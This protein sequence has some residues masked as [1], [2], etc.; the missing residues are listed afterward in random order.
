MRLMIL[1][2]MLEFQPFLRFFR[3]LRLTV[4]AGRK[5]LLRHS[6]GSRVD[7][8]RDS[9]PGMA[10]S[11]VPRRRVIVLYRL[12]RCVWHRMVI[13]TVVTTTMA[14]ATVPGKRTKIGRAHV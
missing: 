7:S 10:V 12:M 1:L 6:G 4:V 5:N 13:V 9:A 3:Q 14:T 8:S 11:I 2:L